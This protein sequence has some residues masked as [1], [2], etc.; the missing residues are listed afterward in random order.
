ME[1]KIFETDDIKIEITV[2]EKETLDRN[3]AKEII[4]TK[5]YMKF[6]PKELE[7]KKEFILNIIVKEIKKVS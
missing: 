1:Q 6:I 5:E 2:E 4:F 3:K 7:D